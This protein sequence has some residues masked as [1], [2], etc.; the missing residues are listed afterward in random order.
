MP[1]RHFFKRTS[2]E[3]VPGQLTQGLCLGD[4][5]SVDSFYRG[6]F[7]RIGTPHQ[8]PLRPRRM[9]A[10]LGAV[11]DFFD[12]RQ[13]ILVDPSPQSGGGH[14]P[15]A[16]TPIHAG[17]ILIRDIPIASF[18]QLE[19]VHVVSPPMRRVVAENPLGSPLQRDPVA[20]TLSRTTIFKYSLYHVTSPRPQG[21]LSKSRRPQLRTNTS[22]NAN[23]RCLVRLRPKN[24]MESCRMRAPCEDVSLGLGYWA[25]E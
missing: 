9:V 7:W 14:P 20:A 16:R 25:Q 8:Y 21:Y 12:G 18:S 5:G 23:S 11:T 10:K 22:K 6:T 17:Q 4:Q 1:R 15:V 13:N 19:S 2:H 24:R 3:S